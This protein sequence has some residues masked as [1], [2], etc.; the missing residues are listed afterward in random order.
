MDRS[1]RSRAVV[2]DSIVSMHECTMWEDGT[3]DVKK[4]VLKRRNRNLQ[5]DLDGEES[6]V[7]EEAIESDSEEESYPIKWLIEDNEMVEMADLVLLCLC[8][9]I[10]D[11]YGVSESFSHLI[12]L[13]NG[14]KT[15]EIEAET[16]WRAYWTEEEVQRAKK[17]QDGSN[18]IVD[19]YD[20]C[21]RAVYELCAKMDGKYCDCDM[22]ASFDCGPYHQYQF[23]RWI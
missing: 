1:C 6:E 9:E 3:D 12:L 7:F 13:E 22:L 11:M 21:M 19:L 5:Q 18:Q 4:S 20:S 17:Q 14:S 15:V 2:P 10:K 8:Y 23:N 16:W